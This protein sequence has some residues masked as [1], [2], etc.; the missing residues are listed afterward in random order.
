M[1]VVPAGCF[2]MGSPPEED[3][4][5]DKEGP[6][7][8][9]T[10]AQPFAVGRYAVTF[11]EWV[12]C[13]NDGGCNF[14]P[15]DQGWG[16]GKRPVIGVNWDDAD[17]YV[18]WLKKTSGKHYRLLTEAEWEYVCRAGS[19]SPFWWGSSIST[20]DANY[21]GEYSYAG[22]PKGGYRRQTLPVDWGKSNDWGLYQVHGN[23]FEWVEDCWHDN[24]HG[25]P[26]DGSPWITE[27]IATG[28]YR[29]GSW[30]DGPD[31]LRSAFRRDGIRAMNKVGFRVARTLT[32]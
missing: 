22:S 8:K 26:S 14:I 10:I 24:Y 18:K 2:E 27:G 9:V 12:A 3:G 19:V 25:A 28:V 17:A 13:V 31:W 1:V 16:R 6:Q 23:V 21:N 5:N 4:H 20:A 7:H 30:N 29:G 11:D 32:P 15:H